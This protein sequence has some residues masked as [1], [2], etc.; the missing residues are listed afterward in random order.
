M[1]IRAFSGVAK[2]A[3]MYY[4]PIMQYGKFAKLYDGFMSGVDYEGWAGYVAGFLPPGCGIIECACGTGEISLRLA[5]RGFSVTAT[6]IS[7]DMLMIASEK[8]RA[9][10]LASAKLRFAQMDMCALSFNKKADAVVACC[11]GVNYLTSRERV[12]A[13]FASAHSVLKPNGLLLFDISSR[14]KLK[15]VLGN[16]CFIDNGKEAA[17]MWQNTYDNETK[18]I[19]MEL[20][21][22]KKT[23]ALYE[24]FDE[25]H[26]QRAHSERELLSWLEECG[27]QAGA[28]SFMS[29][30]PAR[31][32]DERIQF[33]ARKV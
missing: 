5:K 26:I 8:Q 20:S 12:K 18:L 27:F 13:F 33:A 23:G 21:F 28:Y 9:H 17:Y 25:T 7:Q 2:A 1:I 11:D 16:N 31:E 30:E 6:D 14:H 15:N 19:C 3:F 32:D 29:R 4:N 22:F 24:R 10:G